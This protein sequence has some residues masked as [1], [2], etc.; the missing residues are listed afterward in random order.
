MESRFTRLVEALEFRL[1]PDDTRL[2]SGPSG[3]GKT[4]LLQSLAGL[5][6]FASGRVSL[7]GT[8]REAMFVPQLPYIPAGDLRTIVS[9]PLE[10]DTVDDR[11]AQEA[12]TKV[13]LSH[14]VIRLNEAREW[15]KALS[16]GEQQRVAFARILLSTSRALFL[17]ES[18]SALDEELEQML[19]HLI[20]A[21]LPEMI[22]ISVSRRATVEQFRARQLQLIG[23][24]EW[25]LE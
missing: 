11:E 21:E 3:I 16:V 25:R 2:I 17:D 13:A 20:R 18:T 5:W 15:A 23:D 14:L 19:Y 7:P 1:D 8:R 6:P 24:G 22:L 10:D 12:L 9:Y 4:V